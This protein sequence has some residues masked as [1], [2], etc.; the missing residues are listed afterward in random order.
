MPQLSAPLPNAGQDYPHRAAR[1]FGAIPLFVVN[2][3]DSA[4]TPGCEPQLSDADIH[5]W[6]LLAIP[7]RFSPTIG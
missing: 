3:A 7:Q 6:S 1:V 5:V 2:V 4:L